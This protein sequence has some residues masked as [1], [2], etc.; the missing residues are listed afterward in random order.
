MIILK[1]RMVSRRYTRH[2]KEQVTLAAT[3]GKVPVS[4]IAAHFGV[5]VTQVIRWIA[6]KKLACKDRVS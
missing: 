2:F 1:K 4:E 5:N 6:R 3:D